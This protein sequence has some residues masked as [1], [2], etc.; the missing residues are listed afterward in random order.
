MADKKMFASRLDPD[1]L[2][3]LKHL[4]IDTD[5]SIAELLD[6]AVKDLLKKYEKKPKK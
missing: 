5:M 4:S 3:K 2:K 6:E 1:L